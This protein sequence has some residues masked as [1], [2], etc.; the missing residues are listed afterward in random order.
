[1]AVKQ[2]GLVP[3]KKHRSQPLSLF[4][5]LK[6]R[7]VFRVAAAYII[8][9]W[10]LLQVSD[11]L[12]PALHLPEW[13]NS[14]VAFI[15]IIG[16]PLA[17]ILAWAYEI[18]PD[19]LKKESEVDR[20]QSIT[21][22]TGRKLDFTIIAVLAIAI[23]FLASKL[24]LGNDPVS[25]A[26]ATAPD[27]SIAVLV[28]EN[29]SADEEDAGFFAA[30]V[31][32]ELLTLLSNI[33]DLKVI[34]R[35]SVKNLD[36]NLSIPEIGRLLNVA[37]VLE[38][39]VQRAGDRLRINL[40]LIDARQE[41]HLWAT[42]YDR[43]LTAENVFDVQSDIARTV[44]D[45][46]H[47]E[48]SS[49]DEELLNEVPT[50]N[51]QALD[52]YLLGRQLLDQGS[53]ESFRQAER[54]FREATELDPQY[55]QAWIAIADTA[56]QML[57]TG[58]IGLQEY[59]ATATPVIERALELN[60]R[61]PEA[62][63]QQ[64]VLYWRTGDL[65][66]AEAAF[67]SALEL[68]PGYSKTAATYGI[69]L[70]FTG[71]PEEAIS[72]LEQALR[73]DPLSTEILFNLGKAEMYAGRPEKNVQYSE[74]IRQI[75]PTS[76][77]GYTSALQAYLWLGRFD[78]A[79]PWFVKF[80]EVDPDDFEIWGHLGW[81]YHMLGA[82]EW[83]DRYL[84]KALEIAPNEPAVL[85]CYAYALVQQDRF[86]EALAIAQRALEAD[87]DD[88]WYSNSV[89]L[90]LVRDDA[91]VTGDLGPSRQWYLK[92]HPELFESAPTISVDNIYAA[93][94]LSLLL[95]RNGEAEQ[96]D[97]IIQAGLA[98]YQQT[99][100]AAMHGYLTSIVDVSLLALSGDDASA[101]NALGEAAEEGWK[102]DWRW[103]LANKNLDSI[104]SQPRFAEIEARFERE[105]AEQLLVLRALPDMGAFDLRS[106]RK[107]Q[108]V[109]KQ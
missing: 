88:R 37:T 106:Q 59:I 43:E 8:V 109:P 34:S 19:G 107:D 104:R 31:H 70:R 40:Q 46:L 100:S 63:A 29:S 99:Q 74:R 52:R 35:T 50:R 103:H 86:P 54:N 24:W 2:V 49:S 51:T 4:Q 58:M 72:L 47:A 33:S 80:F 62:H 53:F 94:D 48:L 14:G 65:D 61:L 57:Q 56:S 45:A 25:T 26:P 64:G 20:S 12:V 36:P 92:V 21:S 30:G 10:L 96:A 75:E 15:L 11:T 87:M 27:R 41:D 91:L 39:Q 73:D 38:G 108:P 85:K 102:Y 32:D 81:N 3:Q 18:T 84:D 55:V 17:L 13:F 1:M 97:R 6:R 68:K 60:E 105:T 44:S 83:G 5:E 93:A 28:F 78:L 89:F 42:T 67:I 101:L 79:I 90:R 77:Y 95:Q 66:A 23:V 22:Q 98:W 76:V 69:Y 71:N 82:G 7:N 16:F 9:G